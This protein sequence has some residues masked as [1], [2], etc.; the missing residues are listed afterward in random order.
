MQWRWQGKER[1]TMCKRGCA[2]DS[3]ITEDTQQPR[4]EKQIPYAVAC[5]VTN[6]RRAIAPQE[7]L[8]ITQITC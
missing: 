5:A 4:R 1:N 6:N 7:I 2:S 8:L 3:G